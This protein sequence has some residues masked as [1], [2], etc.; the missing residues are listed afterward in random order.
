MQGIVCTDKS[1]SN[2]EAC[3]EKTEDKELY[4]ENAED[5]KELCTKA[6]SCTEKTESKNSI[7]RR[8]KTKKNHAQRRLKTNRSSVQRRLQ[9]KHSA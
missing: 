8:L 9:T 1:T 6:E 4:I 3:A 5:R 2:E 7:Q